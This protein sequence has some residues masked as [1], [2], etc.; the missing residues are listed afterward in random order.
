[1]TFL[2]WQDLGDEPLRKNRGIELTK[3]DPNPAEAQDFVELVG[4]NKA[5][6]ALSS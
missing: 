3:Y 6:C 4:E 5:L 1:M 2:I